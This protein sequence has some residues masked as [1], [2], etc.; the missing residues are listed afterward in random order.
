LSLGFVLP[1]QAPLVSLWQSGQDPFWPSLWS[2]KCANCYWLQHYHHHHL[3][4]LQLCLFVC[5]WIQWQ[6]YMDGRLQCGPCWHV[7]YVFFVHST[8]A[9]GP[10]TKPL[11]SP[12]CM[13]LA[14]SSSNASF[15]EPWHPRMLQACS[16]LQVPADHNTYSL[17]NVLILF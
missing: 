12:L 14:T 9:I 11:S 1:F 4:G 8:L 13:P 6:M 7:R 10:S 5:F 17:A 15:M 3:W 2:V 16:S